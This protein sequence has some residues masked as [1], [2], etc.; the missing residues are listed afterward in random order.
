MRS[1]HA[2]ADSRRRNA[3]ARVHKA[4]DLHPITIEIERLAARDWR[5]EPSPAERS[6]I[7]TKAA[8]DPSR[9]A[10]AYDE[11]MRGRGDRRI[12]AGVTTRKSSLDD[13]TDLSIPTNSPALAAS[14]A[15]SNG[16]MPGGL[17]PSTTAQ[18]PQVYQLTVTD[19]TRILSAGQW[20]AA[21]VDGANNITVRLEGSPA[22]T[23]Q[24]NCETVAE[25]LSTQNYYVPADVVAKAIGLAAKGG[26]V[27]AENLE[28]AFAMLSKYCP[29]SSILRAMT[30]AFQKAA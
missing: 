10:S 8:G 14:A 1:I 6:E 18:T 25:T 17:R 15:S 12:L 16:G 5:P 28:K 13:R 20:A 26:R 4:A 19:V 27:D 24:L 2:I 30:G 9:V 3:D 21:T 11:V 29:A 23:M 22:Q 7:V